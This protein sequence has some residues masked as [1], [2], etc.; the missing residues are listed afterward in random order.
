MRGWLSNE[1]TSI[2]QKCCVAFKNEKSLAESLSG[3]Q[4]RNAKQQTGSNI[5]YYVHTNYHKVKMHAH[6]MEKVRREL[7]SHILPSPLSSVASCQWGRPLRVYRWIN[8]AHLGSLLWT[9]LHSITYIIAPHGSAFPDTP[10]ILLHT[11]GIQW[12]LPNRIE[13]K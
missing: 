1:G 7:R 8:W 4:Q 11:V 13:H 9:C 2:R 3:N 12:C 10:G 6:T 5:K